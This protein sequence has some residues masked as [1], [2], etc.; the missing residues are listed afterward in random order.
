MSKRLLAILGLV[1][2]LGLGIKEADGWYFDCHV[3]EKFRLQ[4]ALIDE[5]IDAE[6]QV[7]ELREALLSEEKT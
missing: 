4:N 3:F 7:Q 5:L 1:A 6:M 2:A